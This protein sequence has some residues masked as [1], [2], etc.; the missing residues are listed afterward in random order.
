MMTSMFA[1]I[2][3]FTWSISACTL[4]NKHDGDILI[5][6]HHKYLKLIDTNLIL[7]TVHAHVVILS[8]SPAEAESEAFLLNLLISLKTKKKLNQLSY[9]LPSNDKYYLAMTGLNSVFMAKAMAEWTLCSNCFK[10]LSNT[11]S[12][13]LNASPRS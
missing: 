10:N 2:I 1:T 6:G 4:K 11:E 7:N 12:K 3:S 9:F 8:G 5:V 13:N